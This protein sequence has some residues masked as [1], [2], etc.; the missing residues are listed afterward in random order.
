MAAL[1]V[2]VLTRNEEENIAECLS[3]VAWADEVIVI[4]SGSTDAT[5]AIAKRFTPLVISLPWKGYGA[6][7]NN[8]IQRATGEWVL[9]LDADER[10]PPEL[11]DEIRRVVRANDPSVAGYSVARRAYFCGKWI[12]HAGWY[13]SRVV[14]L[15]RKELGRLTESNVHE[16]LLLKGPTGEL[17]NDLLHFT[18]PSLQHYFEKFNTYSTLAA[19]DMMTAGRKFRIVDIVVRPLYQFLKM[20][21]LRLGVLDG[22]HGFILSTASSAYVFAKYAKLWELERADHGKGEDR[23]NSST[24]TR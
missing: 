9:W 1:S 12:R 2:I 17:R 16:R 4:D 19:Q 13:P 22:I 10:V 15:F 11:A 24:S 6:A 8:G 7:R 14:R 3:G 23:W 5:M 21:I 20:Y 18:D